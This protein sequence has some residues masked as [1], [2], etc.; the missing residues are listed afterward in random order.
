M[1]SKRIVTQIE[2]IGFEKDGISHM[3]VMF[4]FKDHPVEVFDVKTKAWLAILEAKKAECKH[5]SW[6]ELKT[7][8]Y[9]SVVMGVNQPLT[10]S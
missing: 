6:N 1:S 5:V 4:I 3:R 2:V 9:Y 7:E 8:I 10:I